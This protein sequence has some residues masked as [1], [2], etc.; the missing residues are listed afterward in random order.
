MQME[1][2]DCYDKLFDNVIIMLKRTIKARLNAINQ[3]RLIKKKDG[4][5]KA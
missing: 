4:Q 5:R 3:C 2:F 1:F